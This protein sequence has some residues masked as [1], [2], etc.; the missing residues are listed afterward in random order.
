M[1][2]CQVKQHV[3]HGER[4]GKDS[5]SGWPYLV[6]I[7]TTPV[8][9]YNTAHALP[10]LLR[11]AHRLISVFEC[12]GVAGNLGLVEVRGLQRKRY[13]VLWADEEIAELNSRRDIRN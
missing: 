1:G 13:C 11:Y 10:M 2:T 12:R 4:A 9:P 8:P 7:S 3:V 6:Q 5:A